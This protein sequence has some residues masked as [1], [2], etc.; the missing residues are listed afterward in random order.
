MPEPSTHGQRLE[1]IEQARHWVMHQGGGQ[2][3]GV[4]DWVVRS[5]QRCLARGQLPSTR[6]EFDVIRAQQQQAIKEQHLLLQIG[7]AHV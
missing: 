6:V 5:W 4:S 2:P 3:S 1:R 7:R